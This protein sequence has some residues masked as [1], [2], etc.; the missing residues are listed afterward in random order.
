MASRW[1]G[2]VGGSRFDS[3]KKKKRN[4]KKKENLKNNKVLPIKEKKEK[5]ISFN[6]YRLSTGT[7]FLTQ[8]IAEETEC[9]Y[10]HGSGSACLT[11]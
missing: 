3:Q 4:E 11:Q 7:Q 9:E 1:G 6:R 8:R 10:G 2:D 5:K